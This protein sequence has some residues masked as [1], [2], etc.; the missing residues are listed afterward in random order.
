MPPDMRNAPDEGGAP[1]STAAGPDTP[2]V[3]DDY[4]TGTQPTLDHALDPARHR[5]DVGT[6]VATYATDGRRLNGQRR[7]A[8]VLAQ[9]RGTA[10]A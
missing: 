4:D 10:A 3:R 9:W 8:R 2:R 7:I 5:R 6:E 1:K